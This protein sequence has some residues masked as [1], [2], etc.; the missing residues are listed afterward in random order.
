MAPVEVQAPTSTTHEGV[1]W[2]IVN[3][4]DISEPPGHGQ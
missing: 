1:A 2:V 3:P 4:D